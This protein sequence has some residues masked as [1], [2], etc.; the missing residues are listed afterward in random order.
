[1]AGMS[2]MCVISLGQLSS[3][4]APPHLCAVSTKEPLRQPVQHKAEKVVSA[5]FAGTGVM[6]IH[7]QP[8][9]MRR[10]TSAALSRALALIKQ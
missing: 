7:N 8:R 6:R 3:L 1:M 4:T 10:N 2:Y 5:P 9:V